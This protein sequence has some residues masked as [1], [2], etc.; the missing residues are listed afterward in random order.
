MA[1]SNAE[2]QAAYRQRH[3]KDENAT[4]ERLSLLVDI[5]AKRALERLAARYGVTQRAMLQ[6]LITDAERVVV[7]AL[8]GSEQASYYDGKNV[9]Q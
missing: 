1:Q 7:N 6:T 3:L 2:R 4:D 5:H 8:T 9:R